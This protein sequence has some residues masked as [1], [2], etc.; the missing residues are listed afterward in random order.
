MRW[1]AHVYL[2]L[3]RWRIDGELPPEPKF[4]AIGAPHT[5]NWD[6]VVF[7]GVIHRFRL[8]ARYLGKHTLFRWPFGGLMRRLGGIPVRRD[9][10]GSLAEDVAAEFRAARTMV[11]MMAPE[12]TR[13]A[14]TSW[15][16]G[17]Y[18]IGLAAQVPIVP[19]AI[20]LAGRR[21]AI[22]P[23]IALTGNVG[24]DMDR[25]RTIYATL[26]PE[27]PVTATIRL[28]EE[29]LGNDGA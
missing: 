23:A 21:V 5:S 18:R 20:D 12:G 1:L 2:R 24:A 22:G 9:R 14:T 7:L 11:L 4:V 13:D 19:V 3:R 28:A 8:P 17:F 29:T 27:H 16:S 25:I 26:D 10:P 15:K 6:F